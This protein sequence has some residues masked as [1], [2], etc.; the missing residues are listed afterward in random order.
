M[1]R[2][3]WGRS[4]DAG[5]QPSRWPVYTLTVLPLALAAGIG[6]AVYQYQ[7]AFTTLQ[8]WYLMDY[9]K[10]TYTPRQLLP[11]GTYQLVEPV[12][13]Q[14]IARPPKRYAHADM[15]PWLRETVYDGQAVSHLAWWPIAAAGGVALLGLG[16]AIPLDA[17][18]L[19]V[20]RDG[21]ILR[22]GARPRTVAEFNRLHRTND[23]IQIRVK[24]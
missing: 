23:G 13:E 11:T 5:R 14:Y 18:R 7:V 12:G 16:V 1:A 17:R 6:M 22:G 3:Q 21:K 20:L 15:E 2:H 24:S 10:S 9:L 19:R 4:T 8:Q